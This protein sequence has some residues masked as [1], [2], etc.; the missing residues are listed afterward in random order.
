M[1]RAAKIVRKTKET[2]IVVEL[3]LDGR[4]RSDIRTPL[5]FMNHMLENFSKHS[6]FDLKVTAEGDVH[7]DDHHLVE[8]L[9][10]CLGQALDKALGDKRGIARMGCAS[11]PMDDSLAHIALDLSGRPYAKI[12]L[13]FSEFKA[14]KLGDVSKEAIPHFFES[15]AINGKFNLHINVDGVNDHHKVESCFKAVARALHEA[16]RIKHDD[17]PSTKGVL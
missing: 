7:V 5:S 13:K 4:G 9:G 15:F 16:T 1:K 10:I 17:T 11:V 6:R 2:A 3:D 12:D 8:D 14:A